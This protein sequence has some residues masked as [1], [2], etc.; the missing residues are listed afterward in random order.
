MTET[1]STASASASTWARR[2][3]RFF[4]QRIHGRDAQNVA[5]QFPRQVVI[6]E[7]DVQRLIPRHIIEH[8]G[9]GAVHIGIEHHVQAADFVDQ[10]EEVFQIHILQIH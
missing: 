2:A 6:L 9:Q 8:H 10:P 4:L 1:F 3:I 7:H 5:F